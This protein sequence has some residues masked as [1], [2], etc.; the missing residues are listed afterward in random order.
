MPDTAVV[1]K[2]C[3]GLSWV[4]CVYLAAATAA[5]RVGWEVGCRACL[6]LRSAAL[7]GYSAVQCCAVS[8]PQAASPLRSNDGAARPVVLYQGAAARPA[9]T[10]R[11]R[12]GGL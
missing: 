3:L 7:Q 5:A 9:A 4:G 2:G 10:G 12:C 1:G 8:R 6:Q 11:C